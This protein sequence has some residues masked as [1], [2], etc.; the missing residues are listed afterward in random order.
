MVSPEKVS[1]CL[2]WSAFPAPFRKAEE[3]EAGRKSK[4]SMTDN[5]FGTPNLFLKRGSPGRGSGCF[6]FGKAPVCL[7]GTQI[8]AQIPWAQQSWRIFDSHRGVNIEDVAQLT[9]AVGK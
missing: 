5:N 6:F 2:V 3:A 4:E 8:K 9:E 1:G 7:R